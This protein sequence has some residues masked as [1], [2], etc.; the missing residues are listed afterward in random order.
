M[1]SSWSPLYLDIG[2]VVDMGLATHTLLALLPLAL[3]NQVVYVPMSYYVPIPV[4]HYSVNPVQPVA[5]QIP[6]PHGN[7]RHELVP[8][9]SYHGNCPDT[10]VQLFCKGSSSRIPQKL[11][12]V[13]FKNHLYI[14]R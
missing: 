12:N 13:E 3:G 1:G 8:K 10:M 2:L 4:V 14:L 11:K 5:N 6:T 7:R 9:A